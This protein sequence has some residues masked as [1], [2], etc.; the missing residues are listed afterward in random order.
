MVTNIT[1]NT[2]LSALDGFSH[3]ISWKFLFYR[4]RLRQRGKKQI[5]EGATNE[6][7]FEAGT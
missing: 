3:L 5:D 6:S 2:T 7:L 4:K 1:L